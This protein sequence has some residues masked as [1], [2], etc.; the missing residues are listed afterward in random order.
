MS[1]INVVAKMY[2]SPS[3]AVTKETAPEKEGFDQ[4]V[5]TA[6]EDKASEAGCAN[7]STGVTVTDAADTTRSDDTTA[8]DIEPEVNRSAMYRFTVFIR[9]SGDIGGMSQTLAE[10]F[11]SLTKG[12]VSGLLAEK[13]AGVDV[14]DNYLGQAESSVSKGL[15]TTKSMVND[16]L[17]AADYGLKSVIASMTSNSWMSSL[18]G[19]SASSLTGVSM[20]D[21]AKIYLQDSINKGAANPANIVGSSSAGAV[22]YGGGYQLSMVKGATEPL[23][24]V[25]EQSETPAVAV[26]NDVAAVSSKDKILERFLQLI[27]NMSGAINGK[28]VR[29]GLSISYFDN[30]VSRDMEVRETVPSLRINAVDE[31]VP[32]Q[33]EEVL[34]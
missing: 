16:M 15:D 18:G 21:I 25:P 4:V 6:I 7:C 10:E 31:D 5:K 29:A 26:S 34:I 28:V 20:A 24:I 14:L 19:G 30:A 12:F 13:E 2:D 17:S 9:V 1:A 8:V 23:K 11:A 22:S 27:D 3:A 32:D 33:T